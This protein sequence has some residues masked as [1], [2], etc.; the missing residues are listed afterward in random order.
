[1]LND[2]FKKKKFFQKKEKEKIN[3]IKLFITKKKYCFI[4]N[5]N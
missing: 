3:K 1:M 4:I 2:I 5:K